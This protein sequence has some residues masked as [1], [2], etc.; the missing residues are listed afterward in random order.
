[1]NTYFAYNTFLRRSHLLSVY[2]N[3]HFTN[4]TLDVILN[5]TKIHVKINNIVP[6]IISTLNNIKKQ[7]TKCAAPKRNSTSNEDQE[8][9]TKITCKYREKS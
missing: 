5:G 7:D 1:M 2:N 6:I 8:H 3:L 9:H 4:K